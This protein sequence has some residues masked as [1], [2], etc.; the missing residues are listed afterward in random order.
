MLQP[1]CHSQHHAALLSP[2]AKLVRSLLSALF[3]PMAHLVLEANA[4]NSQVTKAII[5]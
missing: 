1:D 2:G 3:I 4:N 5:L